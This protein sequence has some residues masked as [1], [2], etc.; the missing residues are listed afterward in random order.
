MERREFLGSLGALAAL[1][2]FP[3][4]A[5]AASP[6]ADTSLV[7][8]GTTSLAL[9][10]Y[11]KLREEKGNVFCSPF[12][13][14]A[15][16]AMTARGAAN[17]TLTQ[18]SKTLHMRLAHEQ[19][20]ANFAALIKSLT[21]FD[22]KDAPRLDIANA[23]WAQADYKFKAD[24][25]KD[26]T[27]YYQAGLQT[28][29]FGNAEAA[30]KKINAWVEKQTRDKIKELFAPGIIDSTTRMVLANAIYFKG[31]WLEQFEK[32]STRDESFYTPSEIKVPMMHQNERFQYA[33]ADD[34]QAVQ[35][36]YRG[37][38]LV[39]LVMLP[40][41]REG[42]AA[43]ESKLSADMFKDVTGKLHGQ[44]VRLSLPK[45]KSESA[46][47]LKPTL[48]AMGMTDAFSADKADF[49]RMTEQDRLCI[50]AVVHKAIIE[51]NEEGTE[52]AAA[53]GV[54]MALAAAPIA[55][56]PKIMN[57]DHPFL[58]FIRDTK[59]GTVLFMGRLT[60]PKA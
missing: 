46:F 22:R 8:S 35:M 41:E 30:R 26:M 13:I 53:T 21:T 47:K 51:V 18:M 15:A 7:A 23:I 11:A 39:M 38:S 25:I 57:C 28:V 60:D 42:L 55:D 24:F 17:E 32:E 27:T 50:Q 52:A 20:H 33:E 56:E 16:L 54:G 58:Y 5:W 43:L 9:N 19:T 59:T 34:W 14:A 37:G 40:R 3:Q 45:F 10:L 4:L 12:S 44:K 36:M 31:T 48:E 29:D 6:P 2:R 1:A 49:S